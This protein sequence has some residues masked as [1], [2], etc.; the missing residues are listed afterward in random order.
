MAHR[1]FRLLILALLLT[2]CTDQQTAVTPSATSVPTAH[3]P[4]Q[5]L[6]VA[7]AP[8]R[9]LPASLT[10]TSASTLKPVTPSTIP[11]ATITISPGAPAIQAATAT[12]AQPQPGQATKN[13]QHYSFP[14]RGKGKISYG[15][16]H[17][18]YPATDIF[19]LIGS[20]FLAVTDG[21]VDSVSREDVW[22]P[23]TDDGAAR[24][25]LS[26]AVVGDDGV[27]YYGSH[28]S[29]ITDGIAPGVRVMVGQVLGQTGK[30][31]NA[32]FTEPNLHFGIS[33]PTEPDDWEVRRGEVLP[34]AYLR[35]WQRGEDVTPT[36][37]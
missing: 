36:L 3:P 15:R 19:C 23:I 30:S 32:R 8:P 11:D 14:V 2:A 21:V 17:H 34:Y 12:P 29:R 31:G 35:A 9:S 22:D 6:I 7:S 18:D 27:R 10:P 20:E 5:T 33:R 4:A 1:P 26:V 24:G 25:G 13:A 37:P 28:L 16:Y